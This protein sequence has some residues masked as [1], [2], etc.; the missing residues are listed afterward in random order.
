MGEGE[1]EEEEMIDS[2]VV[3]SLFGNCCSLISVRI[4]ATQSKGKTQQA[5]NHIIS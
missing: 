4:A 1:E 2:G 3:C 5:Y